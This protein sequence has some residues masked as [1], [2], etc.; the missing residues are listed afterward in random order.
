MMAAAYDVVIVLSGSLGKQATPYAKPGMLGIFVAYRTCL[1]Y[2][3]CRGR[4]LWVDS[5]EKL[6]S[7]A[8]ALLQSNDNA[9]DSRQG[10][11]R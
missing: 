7:A 11:V 8:P 10:T 9:T 1:N 6:L 5:V 2:L 3:P 4:L